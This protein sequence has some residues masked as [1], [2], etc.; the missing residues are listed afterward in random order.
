MSEQGFYV[1]LFSNGCKTYYPHNN[2]R[3][4]IIKLPN[5]L[6]LDD[7]GWVCG[8]CEI[9]F[10]PNQQTPKTMFVLLDICQESIVNNKTLPLLRT[11]HF[12]YSDTQPLQIK[13]LIYDRVFYLPLKQQ[14][15]DQI[16]V[17]IKGVNNDVPSFADEPLMCT[18]HFKRL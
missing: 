18:L 14:R 10:T 12:S 8:L 15:V 4:F 17:Y 13:S 3:D 6:Y 7:A 11:V 16:H 9:Q 2:A 5:T 1:S